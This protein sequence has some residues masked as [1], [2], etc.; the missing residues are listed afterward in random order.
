MK[1]IIWLSISKFLLLITSIIGIIFC[2]I[3]VNSFG[4]EDVIGE[5][6]ELKRIEFDVPHGK[7]SGHRMYKYEIDLKVDGKNYPLTFMTEGRYQRDYEVN[8]KIKVV[9][10][11]INGEEKLA[12]TRNDVKNRETFV[13]AFVGLMGVS[14]ALFVIDFFIS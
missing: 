7:Y 9:R 14:I 12:K 11:T 2:D 4:C 8:D 3:K 5:I 6:V 1:K 13:T 10:Y